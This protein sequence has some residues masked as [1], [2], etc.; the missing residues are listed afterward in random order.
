M[1]V[2]YNANPE[3]IKIGDCVIRAISTALDKPYTDILYQLYDISNYFNCDILVKDCYSILLSDYYNLKCYDG[4]GR[5][6]K[7]VA[8]DF[9]NDTLIIRIEGHLT[10][11]KKGDI[12][13]IWNP[14]NERVDYFWV[15][16]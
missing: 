11:S 9:F 12:I 6:V 3:N 16:K 7:E 4:M 10:C 1:F 2:Y 13:D 8:E 5:T 15:V 14:S